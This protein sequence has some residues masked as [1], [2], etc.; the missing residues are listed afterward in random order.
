MKHK[1]TNETITIMNH[2]Y[3]KHYL[4]QLHPPNKQLSL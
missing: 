3:Y 2:N 4:S 1:T